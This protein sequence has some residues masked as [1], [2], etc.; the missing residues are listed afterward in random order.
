MN[1]IKLLNNIFYFST[2]LIVGGI[3][4]RISNYPTAPY[5]FLFG[6]VLFVLSRLFN[7][8][9]QDDKVRGRLSQIQ[10]FSGL[11]LVVAGYFMYKG[12]NSWSV[13]VLISALIELYASFRS[14]NFNE[15]TK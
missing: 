8:W 11:S 15:K 6:S 2:L 14:G 7:F 4:L 12:G 5:I 3:L 1:K 10:I 9:F 13:F